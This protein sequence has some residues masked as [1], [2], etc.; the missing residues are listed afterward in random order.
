MSIEPTVFTDAVHIGV[1]LKTNIS[2][3]CDFRTFT[4]SFSFVHI[5]L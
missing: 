3:P 1:D 2:G 4:F 5:Q